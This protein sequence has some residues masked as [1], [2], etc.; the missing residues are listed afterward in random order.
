MI[1]T[2]SAPILG[3][4]LQSGIRPHTSEAALTQ[5]TSDLY[6]AN[7]KVSSQSVSQLTYHQH[8]M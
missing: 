8:L 3:A 6:L 5:V 2:S 7:F 1:T 4:L